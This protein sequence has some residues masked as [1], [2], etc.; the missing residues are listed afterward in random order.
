MITYT[1]SINIPTLLYHIVSYHSKIVFD[2]EEIF[3]MHMRETSK[4]LI[5]ILFTRT[6][7]YSY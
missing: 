2:K 3:K 1:N 7:A 4:I 6:S 5:R